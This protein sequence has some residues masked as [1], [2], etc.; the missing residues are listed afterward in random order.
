M[1]VR[2]P[3]RGE[4]LA[5]LWPVGSLVLAA[6][7]PAIGDWN[8]F[9][10]P[11]ILW[12]W[13]LVGLGVLAAL[14]ISRNWRA[15]GLLAI[16]T[17]LTFFLAPVVS[18]LGA[19]VWNRSQFQRSEAVYADVVARAAS[20]PNEGRIG[21][22]GYRI[23]RGPPTRIAFPLPVGVA[24]NWSAVVHDP[25]DAVATVRGRGERPG[26]DT[27]RPDLRALWG[28]QLVS[29][30]RITGHYFRCDFT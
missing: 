20:L 3:T 1:S 22:V 10:L 18:S 14:L 11:L 5:I 12:G 25:S 19:G 13:L 8:V 26:D 9:F 6:L 29:C 4:W 2:K 16:L 28:G 23:E 15:A 27:A 24:D 30:T 7:V 17:F 21:A